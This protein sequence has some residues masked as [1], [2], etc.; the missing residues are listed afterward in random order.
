MD[1]PTPSSG[2][3]MPDTSHHDD[4]F[5]TTRWTI[6]RE[7]R[8]DSPHAKAALEEICRTYWFPLYAY[9]RRRGHAPA[10]AEDLTQEFFRRL[11]EH[12]W[13]EDADR[14]KGKL[15]AF[16]IT[17]MKRFMAKEWRRASA[18][19]R[20]GGERCLSIDAG[21]AEDRYA[22]SVT[23]SLDAEALFD[24]QWALAVLEAAI[25]RLEAE[26]EAAGKADEFAVL[27]GSLALARE[28][29]SYAELAEQLRTS[30]G[31]ARVAVHRFRKR[32]RALYRDEVIQTMPDGADPDEEAR[33]LA[34]CLVKG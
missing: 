18:R 15:R 13:I 22:D 11:L 20:G 3:L 26:F 21:V 33:Y 34:G 5:V 23:P 2:E 27:K 9:A 25:R 30:E 24:R 7:A 14:E 10:D 1:R 28:A 17:A 8:E 4:I 19:R 29:I 16:L 12:R 31:A 32:F 6:V